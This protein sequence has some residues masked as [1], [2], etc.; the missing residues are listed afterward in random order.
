MSYKSTEIALN[1]KD[2]KHYTKQELEDK[3]NSEIKSPLLKK[4]PVAPSYLNDEQKKIFKKIAK[5]LIETEI[6]TALDIDSLAKY[7]ILQYQYE[8]LTLK[9]N[10]NPMLLLDKNFMSQYAKIQDQQLKLA[11]ELCLTI[12]S[13]SKVSVVKIETPKNQNK[14]DDFLK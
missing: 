4:I 9:S 5:Q 12:N 10:E 11:K 2:G 1:N 14:F 8:F 7:C 3:K 13:R 6:L